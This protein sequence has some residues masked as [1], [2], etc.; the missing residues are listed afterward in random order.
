[1][2]AVDPNSLEQFLQDASERLQ[3]LREYAALPVEPGSTS[4]DLAK[5]YDAAHVLAEASS[6]RGF[7][8]FAD[9]AGRLAH[10]FQ[11]ARKAQL[12]PDTYGPLT[13]FLADA[14]SVLEFDLLQISSDGNET[15]E[16][17][18]AFKHR[19]AFAFAGASAA[20]SESPEE[21]GT[22]SEFEPTSSLAAADDNLADDLPEDDDVPRE[23][24]DFF[25]PEAE[26]HLQIA[27][28]CLLGLESNPA[29]E[30]IHRLFRSVHTIKGSAA[31]VGLRRL[32]AV[33][34]LL[35]D[36]IGQ[37]RDGALSCNAEITDVSLQTVD[38]LRKFLH[39]QWAS[40]DDMRSAVGPLLARIVYW[41]PEDLHE[42]RA[43]PEEGTQTE[44]TEADAAPAN[45]AAAAPAKSG[46]RVAQSKSVRISLSRLDDMMNSVG[47]LVINRTRLVGRMAELKKLVE[48]LGISRK[49]LSDKVAEFQEKYE[50]T[51][52][53]ISN[54][55]GG[56]GGPRKAAGFSQG[57]QQ[58][59]P[60]P[61]GNAGWLDFS[62]LEMDRYD[63]FN[64]L[65]RSLTEISAD[66]S[67]VLS[68]LGG[69]VGRVGGDIDEF[70]KLGHHLQDE[71][72]EARM[73]PIGNLYTRLS[74]TARD[75]AKICGKSVDLELVG[76][77]TRLDNNIVQQI[78]DP[79]IHLVRNAIAHGIEDAAARESG[80][81]SA[82]GK[83]TVR[84]FH[85]GNHVFI[86]VEDDG[87]G[88]DYERIRQTGIRAGLVSSAA[89]A[90]LSENEL[91]AFLFHPGFTTASSK[92]EIAGRGVG[93]DV[94][95]N[96]VH[97]LNGEIE[98]RSEMG[99][100]TCFGVK[101]PLTLI[102]SQAL[103]IRSGSTVLAMPLA[104]VEEIRR[105][106]PDDIEDIGGKLLTKV[107]GVIT[108]VVR[109]DSA[110]G[111][112]PIEP[113]NGYMNMVIVRA[114]GRQLG[115]VV[116]EVL[117]KDEVVI[118]N[119]GQYLRRVKL[120]PGATISTDGSLIL[121]VDVNRLAGTT[122]AEVDVVVPSASA[123]RIFGP[124][125]LAVA[126]GSIPAAAV[127]EPISE[128]VVVIAD[129]SISVRK[130]VGRILEKA[131]YS[132]KL[133][134]DGLE[135]S[136]L[137]A[138][139]GCHLVISDIEMP[140]MNGYELMSHLRQDPA[141][142]RIPVL[143]VTSRAG[144][145]HR[146]RAM[147][148]GAA[149]FLTKPVQEEQLLAVVDQLMNSADRQRRPVAPALDLA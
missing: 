62:E 63:D 78:T 34:H 140:R 6:Q 121:L 41:V 96:N 77:D 137:I 79:L 95:R 87:S 127:D 47:E 2:T 9:I 83:V 123:A 82:R 98:V 139:V 71:I 106:R 55:D 132:V 17:I 147:K 7:Q 101:V 84:A 10:V 25:I 5:L 61:A 91:R 102:I 20:I 26:E 60:P 52:M 32:G 129:D 146:E 48:V 126:S 109:L 53:G 18:A 148:E 13:E 135:A 112:P 11:Y 44:A 54:P 143:V 59:T 136:E 36:L 107:R 103:F 120:F 141:T 8:L 19:Y 134:S 23:V 108:E 12:S 14:I 88:L 131:G 111:L 90:T 57:A 70:T 116:E 49:R 104:V 105:L 92:N 85:R 128:K 64:I 66:I 68:Q 33:A 43:V 144:A 93:L 74:R 130:F 114:A 125:A 22:A 39:R 50:F 110:L 118:K 142:R 16:D 145:K 80:R 133:A 69:F 28:Q 27:T 35:E 149:S 86:E 72:T 38:A 115:V 37:L 97:A 99:K 29:P 75:A 45:A 51:R 40:D 138:Q 122:A 21:Q 124:G 119:L 31:Q 56:S 4:D 100:G 76:E 113:I 81:K 42:E 15:T 46:E 30:E 1:M 58:Q 67:E 117:G 3:Y 89:A 73:V 24:L 94:V 65:S